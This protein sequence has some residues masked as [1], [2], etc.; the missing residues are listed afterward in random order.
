VLSFRLQ[1]ILMEV[2]ALLFTSAHGVVAL[3]SVTLAVGMLA[4]T[5]AVLARKATQPIGAKARA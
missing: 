1:E 2:F 4:G 3:T 5:L